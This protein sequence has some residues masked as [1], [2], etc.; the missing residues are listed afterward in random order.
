MWTEKGQVQRGVCPVDV[1]FE[2]LADRLAADVK[3][4]NPLFGGYALGG[5]FAVLAIGT[6]EL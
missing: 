4:D 3:K 1:A 2:N 5:Q 6:C